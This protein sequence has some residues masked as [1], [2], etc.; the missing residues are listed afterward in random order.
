MNW[1]SLQ[2]AGYFNELQECKSIIEMSLGINSPD[3]SDISGF[4]FKK[5]RGLLLTGPRGTGK[6]LLM[7][8]LRDYYRP[9]FNSVHTLSAD[10]LLS[11]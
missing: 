7:N 3:R 1:E 6:T 8:S 10:I 9:F 2:F 11:R 4:Q 5:P